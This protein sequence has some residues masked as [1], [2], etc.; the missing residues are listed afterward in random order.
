MKHYIVITDTNSRQYVFEIP[1]TGIKLETNEN[2]YSITKDDSLSDMFFET[3]KQKGCFII[4]DKTLFNTNH[5]VG[6]E[7]RAV[8]E[9]AY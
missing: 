3:F 1:E 4:G 2:L 5:L 8:A 7:L 9:D 6:I